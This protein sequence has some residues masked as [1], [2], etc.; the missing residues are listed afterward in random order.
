MTRLWLWQRLARDLRAL[1]PFTAGAAW[2]FAAAPA[3]AVPF[4]LT[5]QNSTVS[6]DTATSGATNWTVDG[7][8]QLFQ[9][10]FWYRVGSSTD[11]LPVA[12]L[13]I[14]FQMVS[15]A[16]LNPGDDTLVVTYQG[17]GFDIDISLSLDG[18]SAGSGVSDLAEQITITNTSGS[19]LDFHFFEYTDLDLG[20]GAGDDSVIFP[21]AN[22]V[23]QTDAT[24]SLSETVA[25]PTPSHHEA[26]IYD[27]ILTL[28]GNGVADNL[29][30]TPAIGTQ[31]GPFDVTWAFQWDFT[32]AAG[33]AV[34][35]SKDKALSIVPEPGTG[36][37]LALGLGGLVGG[38]RK[39]S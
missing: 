14:S 8:D 17:T 11:E 31:I 9:E 1:I 2:L 7:T 12:G 28:F 39:R 24:L 26:A 23:K 21:N 13:P 6:G 36:L 29:N 3:G 33:Q 4:T 35:I 30:D 16:N 5:D 37:L 22:T 20:G 15:D 34:N 18:G 27:T 19:V 10:W 32:L 38:R 25:T